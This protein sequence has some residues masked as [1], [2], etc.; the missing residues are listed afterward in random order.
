MAGKTRRPVAGSSTRDREYVFYVS[1]G[2]KNDFFNVFL[3]ITCQKSL[4]NN[5]NVQ[6]CRILT[7]SM[8]IKKWNLYSIQCICIESSNLNLKKLILFLFLSK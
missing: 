6:K 2:L 5:G 7:A 3:E 1:Y 4:S 8:S